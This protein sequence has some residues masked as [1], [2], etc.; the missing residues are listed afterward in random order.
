MERSEMPLPVINQYLVDVPHRFYKV[1]GIGD[2]YAPKNA[3][4]QVENRY[5]DASASSPRTMPLIYRQ[6]PGADTASLLT[7]YIQLAVD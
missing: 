4:V 3:P 2:L 5:R 7:D 1:T 6:R